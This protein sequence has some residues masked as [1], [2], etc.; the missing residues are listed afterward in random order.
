M[1]VNTKLA[2][3]DFDVCQNEIGTGRLISLSKR[4]LHWQITVSTKFALA[5]YSVNEVCIGRLQCQRSLH[6]Q[7]TVSTKFALADYSVNEVCIGRLQCQ[8]SLHWQ[9]RMSMLAMTVH[10]VC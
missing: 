1:F 6:W 2:I 4:S 5:D 8:R 10:N 7:I 9:I 3:A